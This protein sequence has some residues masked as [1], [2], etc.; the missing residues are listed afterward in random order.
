IRPD[1]FED[2]LV[3]ADHE[4][5]IPALSA[6]LRPG[7][8][9]IQ[10]MPALRRQGIAHLGAVAGRRRA[11]IDDHRVLLQTFE[12]AARSGDHLLGQGGIPDAEED[13]VRMFRHLSWS[14]ASD[15]ALPAGG[16]FLRLSCTMR[17][18]R[19]F[20]TGIDQVLSH[21]I[22]HDSESKKTKFCQE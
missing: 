4:R 21:G 13:A 6:W 18:E 17:P 8:R 22:A 5:Q 15:R 3:A 2:R 20:M 14:I 10:E 9:R 12:Q 19:D 1:L 16:K 11:G 7:A